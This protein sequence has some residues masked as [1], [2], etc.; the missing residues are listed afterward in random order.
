[1]TWTSRYLW[2]EILL[3]SQ[4]RDLQEYI[5]EVSRCLLNFDGKEAQRHSFHC[6]HS[7]LDCA[8]LQKSSRVC[9]TW[10]FLAGLKWLPQMYT[11]N[12]VFSVSSSCQLSWHLSTTPKVSFLSQSMTACNVHKGVCKLNPLMPLNWIS[13][14]VSWNVMRGKSL[15]LS[16]YCIN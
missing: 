10:P 1:M 2:R 7:V 8:F 3:N 5:V 16:A 6:L 14:T 15:H 4:H 12:L 11:L 9:A 13:E